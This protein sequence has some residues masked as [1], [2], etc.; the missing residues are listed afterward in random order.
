M[1]STT[2]W[3]FSVGLSE[4]RTS[5]TVRCNWLETFQREELALQRHQQPVGGGE[6]VHGE[7]VELGGQS[8]ST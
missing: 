6:R 1:V 4:P 7:K 2:P 5:S 3:I 8:I